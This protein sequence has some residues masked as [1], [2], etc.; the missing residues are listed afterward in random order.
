LR[1]FLGVYRPVLLTSFWYYLVFGVP[2]VI[3]GVFAGFASSFET[4]DASLFILVV[5]ISAM[6][7]SALVAVSGER[8]TEPF[9]RWWFLLLVLALLGSLAWTLY[10]VVVSR[11]SHSSTV[12]WVQLLAFAVTLNVATWVRFA[13]VKDSSIFDIR[14]NRRNVKAYFEQFLPTRKARDGGTT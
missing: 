8:R 5:L 10:F 13:F 12:D 9:P 14:K 7:E 6:G 2:Y 4:G 11:G 3:Y 1:G